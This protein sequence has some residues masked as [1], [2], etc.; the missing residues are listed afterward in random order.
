VLNILISCQSKHW[1]YANSHQS[2]D[3]ANL[4]KKYKKC[5]TGKMQSPINLS[6]EQSIR[7]KHKISI[8]YH[9]DYA[10]IIDDGHTIKEVFSSRNY[11]NI[12]NKQY[13]LKQLHFHNHSEHSLEGIY[14]PAEVHFVHQSEDG[15]L[16]VLGIFIELTNK[17]NSSY[18]FFKNIGKGRS[19]VKLS[20]ILKLNGGHFYY[21]GSLTTPPCSENVKWIILDKHI[22]VNYS[23]LKHFTKHYKNNYRPT[24][25][26]KGH[27]LYHSAK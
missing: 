1:D 15:Q 4:N 19:L 10:Q 5:S 3:W 23:Q 14:Y 11:I 21:T 12:D 9:D 26:K 20:K 22:S 6:L 2:Q 27:K 24:N 25:E 17:K 13:F 16:A 18:G 7:M 8:N